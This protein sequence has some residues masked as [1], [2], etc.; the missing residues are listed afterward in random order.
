MIPDFNRFVIYLKIPS[1][2]LSNISDYTCLKAADGGSNIDVSKVY[3]L[4]NQKYCLK[5]ILPI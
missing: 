4:C 5:N 2:H 1:Q 3:E